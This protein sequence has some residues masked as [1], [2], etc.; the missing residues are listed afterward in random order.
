MKHYNGTHNRL[1]AR[2]LTKKVETFYHFSYGYAHTRMPTSGMYSISTRE[3]K[4]ELEVDVAS[5]DVE[6]HVSKSI[7]VREMHSNGFNVKSIKVG[8]TEVL[9]YRD[10]QNAIGWNYPEEDSEEEEDDYED[11]ASTSEQATPNKKRKKNANA[12]TPKKKRKKR[13]KKQNKATPVGTMTKEHKLAKRFRSEQ[14]GAYTMMPL[15]RMFAKG[16]VTQVHAFANSTPLYNLI[17]ADS[18][19]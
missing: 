19:T 1:N 17:Y 18:H 13:G 8:A 2:R 3:G 9:L 4:E 14:I 7:D 5:E 12:K 15:L 10:V 16:W 6:E 11:D